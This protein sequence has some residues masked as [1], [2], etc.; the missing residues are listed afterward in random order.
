MGKRGPARTPTA[1]LERRGSWRAERRTGEPQAK[2]GVPKCPDWLDAE[3]RRIWAETL[4]LVEQMYPFALVDSLVFG[5]LCDWAA[6]Y[7]QASRVA[8]KFP[9]GTTDRR[10]VM[11][12][13]SEAMGHVSRLSQ[14]FGLTPGDR[15]GLQVGGQSQEEPEGK[16]RFFGMVG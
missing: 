15:A 5:A 4:P 12:E 7:L 16:A 1:T 3:G 6:K 14:R 10:R 2:T 8:V 9:Y 11:A 13:A